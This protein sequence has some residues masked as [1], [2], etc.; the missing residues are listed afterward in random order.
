MN[1]YIADFYKQIVSYKDRYGENYAKRS[2]H[3]FCY[4][5]RH[6]FGDKLNFA[7]S[8][9]V[10]NI[11]FIPIGGIG[12]IVIFG[13]YMDKF[14]KK[15]DCD[16]KI[17][18]FVQQH[19]DDIGVLFKKYANQVQIHDHDQFTHIP[20]DMLIRFC[21]Q[22]PELYFFRRGYIAKKSNFLPNYADAISDFCK[23][24]KHLFESEH[25]F[26]QQILLDI[27]GLNRVS[28]MD[29][30]KMLDL[31]PN[32]K[33]DVVI[34]ENAKDILKKYKLS[35]NKFITFTHDIDIRNRA[36]TSVRLW[37]ATHMQ[38][39]ITKLKSQYPEYKIVQLGTKSFGNFDDVDLNLVGK[40]SFSELMVLLNNSKI[41]VDAE[42]GM[43]HLRHAICEKTTVVLH[44]PTSISTK[45]YKENINIRSNVCNC[46]CCEWLMGGKWHEFCVKTESNMP[47]CMAAI[48]PDMVMNKIKGIL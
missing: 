32:D 23:K 37:P 2:W 44:G 28:G 42:C 33:M 19:V 45:G 9:D 3:T 31:K 20:L 1:K 34:P 21:V 15:L 7:R 27:M 11:G 40:T 41:H 17:H 25:I 22:F 43:V 39:L 26:D 38:K 16:F 48:N 46:P 4:L 13:A 6:W 12:D 30:V 5:I 14:I 10:V 35:T 18:I 36:K 29:P 8:G 24:Y 47:A